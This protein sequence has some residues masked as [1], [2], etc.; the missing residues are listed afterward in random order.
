MNLRFTR[1]VVDE[2]VPKEVVDSLNSLGFKEVH[3][4]GD[5]NKGATDPDVWRIA[6]KKNAILITGDLGFIPQMGQAEVLYGPVV[7]EY[8]TRGFS[9]N[10]LKNAEIMGAIIRWF[11]RNGHHEDKEHVR[12]HVEGKLGTRRRLWQQAKAK[13]KLHT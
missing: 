9:K 3:W 4:I 5:K 10:E 12:I 1:L 6:T 8:S 11:F 13:E 7:V 2:N